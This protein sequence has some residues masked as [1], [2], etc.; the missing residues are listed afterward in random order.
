MTDKSSSTDKSYVPPLVW[1][2]EQANGGAFASINKP[3]AG[4]THQQTLPRG[5]HALQLYS[6]ATPNGMKV[7]IMLEEL[8]QAGIDAAE[9]DAWLISIREGAQF[10]SDFVALNPNSKIPALYDYSVTP[11][12]RLFESG[13]ILLYLAEKFAALLPASI[14]ERTEVLN[15]LFWQMGSAPFVG[16][17]F[18]HFYH[19]APEKIQ[20]PIDRYAMETKRQLS[21]LDQLLANRTYIAGDDYSIAD[22]AIWPWYGGLVLGRLYEAATFLDVESYP[23]VC[24]WAKLID[25]RPAVRRGYKVNR[26][27]GD[28]SEQLPERHSRA[29]FAKSEY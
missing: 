7:S 21:V 13:S 2:P 22:I 19:Y 17:G 20:Y 3:T 10:G 11:T 1:S 26:N 16:G 29:D 24:R 5:A 8:I 4:A 12:L 15:W 27:W 14:A 28:A 25:A 9:Y 23:H 18:G 6:L